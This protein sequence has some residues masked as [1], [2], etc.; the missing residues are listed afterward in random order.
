MSKMK[1]NAF[2]LVGTDVQF[3]SLVGKGANRIPFRIIKK[4]DDKMI[5]LHKIGQRLF[6]QSAGGPEIIA[7]I[8][9]KSADLDRVAKAFEAAGLDPQKFGKVEGDSHVILGK[10]D[11]D[12]AEDTAVVKLSDDVALAVSGL[13]KSFSSYSGDS[14][15][16]SEVLATES[17]Y[18]SCRL[19]TEAL[20]TVIHNI[21]YDSKTPSDASAAV[22]PIVDQFKAY[23]LALIGGLPVQAFKLDGELSKASVTIVDESAAA[24]ASAE[25]P[26]SETPQPETV[27]DPAT[28]TV[29]ETPADG[30]VEKTETP[31]DEASEDEVAA[32]TE[33]TE[34][35]HQKVDF[36]E[37]LAAIGDLKKSF[38]ETIA[39]VKTDVAAVSNRV[40]DVAVMAK[41]TEAELSGT[42]LAEAGGD[43]KGVSKSDRRSS[44]P[45]LLD[46]AYDRSIA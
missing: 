7:A 4:E 14:T 12:K 19:A 45:P 3:V 1:L 40:E 41:K 29:E 11:F 44:L 13:R 28:D 10:A 17:F 16:F 34:E 46:T 30:V 5:D 27:A 24:P 36:A 31:S 26:A 32:V 35:P 18:T 37:V 33:A 39:A 6:K 21:L 25:D 42:V 43:S 9:S 15:S 23:V 22:G 20:S 2:E 38:E 8:V